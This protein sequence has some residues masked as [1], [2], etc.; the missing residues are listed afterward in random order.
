MIEVD[1]TRYG[2][3]QPPITRKGTPVRTHLVFKPWATEMTMCGQ[4][5]ANKWIFVSPGEVTKE[6]LCS[7]CRGA[8]GM[9]R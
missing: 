1:L 9:I 6:Q 2:V 5:V 7:K 8:Q 3:V 4:F